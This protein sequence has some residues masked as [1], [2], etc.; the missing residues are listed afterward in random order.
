MLRWEWKGERG[1]EEQRGDSLEVQI[2]AEGVKR[3]EGVFIFNPGGA[4]G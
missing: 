1:D 4:K 2:A 3:P